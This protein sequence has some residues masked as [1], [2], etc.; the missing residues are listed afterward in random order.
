MEDFRM[1][2]FYPSVRDFVGFSST[3]RKPLFQH[4]YIHWND[5]LT[6]ESRSLVY[7]VE[8]RPHCTSYTPYH[9]SR[10]PEHILEGSHFAR[11]NQLLTSGGLL[12]SNKKQP[13]KTS[14][15]T[16]R[17]FYS[18]LKEHADI[19][20]QVAAESALKYARI[21]GNDN[22]Q[23]PSG[24]SLLECS[25]IISWGAFIRSFKRVY[26]LLT[27]VIT[28]FWWVWALIAAMSAFGI[29][30]QAEREQR[31]PR[32][33]DSLWGDPAGAEEE[34]EEELFVET[35]DRVCQGINRGAKQII[36]TLAEIPI[37]VGGATSMWFDDIRYHRYRWIIQAY[38]QYIFTIRF[39]GVVFLI[40]F[41]INMFSIPTPMDSHT[42]K[43][44]APGLAKYRK[45]EGSNSHFC[46][47]ADP[48][49]G[50]RPSIL[51]PNTP[52]YGEDGIAV[53]WME[54]VT[55][56]TG[57]FSNGALNHE[58]L[59]DPENTSSRTYDTAQDKSG[60]H[61]DPTSAGNSV[62]NRRFNQFS[63]TASGV[64]LHPANTNPTTNF[65]ATP[66]IH[67]DLTEELDG[68]TPEA[69]AQSFYATPFHSTTHCKTKCRT[70]ASESTPG[71]TESAGKTRIIEKDGIA[72]CQECGQY[73]CCEIRDKK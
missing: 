3:S 5:D 27:F 59:T 20:A 45:D 16:S 57:I 55:A 13:R 22:V 43:V 56:R 42:V 10:T 31:R 73:H 61:Y 17:M 48:R 52:V 65:G 44:N 41:M 72:Y 68:P 18:T 14:D 67:P 32:A 30:N 51:M 28:K 11:S 25:R 33:V 8:Y 34:E 40:L 58:A 53:A 15:H 38:L 23:I 26:A 70:A 21:I 2:P 24:T 7:E 29:W 66:V 71:Q 36:S 69:S 37:R 49:S 1:A 46:K 47:P 60:Q 39:W 12:N 19:S 50:Q 62:T 35:I 63:D 54:S 64:T 4:Q 6:Y 9:R